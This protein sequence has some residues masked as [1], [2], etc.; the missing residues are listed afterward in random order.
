MRVAVIGSRGFSVADIGRY[1]PAGTD[2]IVS[3]GARGVDSCA[4]AYARSNGLK[5]TEF[6]PDYSNFGK[7]A[8]LL[9]NI[10]I[11]EY[12]DRVLA[13]WDGESHGTRF[14]IKK[15]REFNKPID[16][17]MLTDVTP[18]GQLTIPTEKD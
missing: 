15:C 2:E 3:G 18:S 1:L 11:I 10:K 16:V 12:A 8:P 13:F 5:F 14:V 4:A 17:V 6:L 7:K 9:R